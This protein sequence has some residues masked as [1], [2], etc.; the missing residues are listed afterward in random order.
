MKYL[1]YNNEE[2]AQLR[3]DKCF[4]D[5]IHKEGTTSYCIVKSMGNNSWGV[6]IDP[7]TEYLFTE[8]ELLEAKDF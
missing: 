5:L 1:I 8:Q 7:R 4:N 3:A 6:V 2:Q